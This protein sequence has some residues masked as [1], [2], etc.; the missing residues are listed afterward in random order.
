MSAEKVI[1]ALARAN[2][3]LLT[4]VPIEQLHAGTIPLA[5]SLPALAYTH[6]SAVER[7]TIDSGE[8][9]TSVTARMQITVAAASYPQKK[10]VLDLVR[11]AFNN[12]RGEIAG[13]RVL[14]VRR[15]G[16]GP[17]L[18]NEESGVF[19]RSNDFSV[20]FLEPK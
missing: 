20:T 4:V 18:D 15:I 9:F 19:T 17:D 10:Q 6:V 8:P 12:Q 5:A 13:V 11:R 16:E 2:A 3:A 1:V 14:N 7:P